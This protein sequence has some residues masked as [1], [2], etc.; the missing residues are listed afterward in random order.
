MQKLLEPS[1]RNSH[2]PQCGRA[3]DNVLA[4]NGYP[5]KRLKREVFPRVED[6]GHLSS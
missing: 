3:D 1:A 4:V 5:A 2:D 6:D